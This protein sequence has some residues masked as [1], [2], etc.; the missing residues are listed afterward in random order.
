MSSTF[1][2]IVDFV[3]E[4]DKLDANMENSESVGL[5]ILTIFKSKGLGVSYC[6]FT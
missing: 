5:Q 2:N 4:V 3:Y 6:N 1:N